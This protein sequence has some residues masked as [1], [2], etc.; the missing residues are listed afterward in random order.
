M[1]P[2][3]QLSFAFDDVHVFDD[4][5]AVTDAL[6][7]A[8][9]ECFVDRGLA[10]G[11]PSVDRHGHVCLVECVECRQ[12][13]RGWEAVLGTGDVEADDSGLRPL[14]TVPDVV[15]QSPSSCRPGAWR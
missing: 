6:G 7:M 9:G 13:R 5:S 14:L 11:F 8:D 15:R 2:G 12:V 4:A 10:C 1:R 3:A